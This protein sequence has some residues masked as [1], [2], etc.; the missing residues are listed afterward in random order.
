MV[1]RMRGGKLP[2][3][4]TQ[5]HPLYKLAFAPS[6]DDKLDYTQPEAK[7]LMPPG[8]SLWKSP[9][10]GSWGC[11]FP[12]HKKHTVPFTRH[13]GSSNKALK[14][15]VRYSWELYL[16]DEGG[17]PHSDCPITGI[18]ERV[19]VSAACSVKKT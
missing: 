17:L 7:P 4:R 18:F 12:P 15:L 1:K 9:A 5:W 19:A 14:E 16:K 10:M 3:A 6:F 13:G 11:Y 8:C 2:K